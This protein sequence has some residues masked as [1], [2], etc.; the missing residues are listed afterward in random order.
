MVR[1]G[2]LFVIAAP[3]G[4]GK[5]S[6]VAA[7]AERV[8]GVQV[9]I[10]YTTRAKRAGEQHGVNY[11]F[12]DDTS[13]QIMLADGAFL[14]HATVFGYHYGTSK[15]WVQQKLAQGVDIIL[16]IDWQGAQQ[17]RALFANA[18]SIFI[19]PPSLE[20]LSQRLKTRA[21]DDVDTIQS[22]MDQ[23]QL[24]LKHYCEFDYLVINQDFD[25][26]LLDLQHIIY[27][28]RL[29]YTEQQVEQSNLLADLLRNR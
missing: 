19:L 5:T 27:A 2:K 18:V 11:Y 8:P 13:Y 17:I 22:R 3:S 25:L 14:E 10:S 9:S 24:E 26:A 1:T 7:L 12:I 6:L 16:E 20:A 23:A 15:W 21:Q 29:R 4:A 28:E